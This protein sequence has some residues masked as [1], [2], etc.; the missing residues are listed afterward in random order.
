MLRRNLLDKWLTGPMAVGFPRSW[1]ADPVLRD[2]ALAR[3]YIMVERYQM[4]RLLAGHKRHMEACGVL[5]SVLK[6]FVQQRMPIRLHLIGLIRRVTQRAMERAMLGVYLRDQMRNEEIR[7]RTKVTDIAQ[8][9]P[10]LKWQWAG[11]IVRR[12]DGRWGS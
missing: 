2:A 10:K 3:L 1:S 12:T 4:L 9:V 6:T 8:R 11:H 5:I 7:G